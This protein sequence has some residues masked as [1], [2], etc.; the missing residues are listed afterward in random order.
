MSNKSRVH[1]IGVFVYLLLLTTT[2]A[3]MDES[4]EWTDSTGRFKVTAKLREVQDDSVFLITDD[5]RTLKIAIER[6]SS[7]DQEFL[8]SGANPFEDVGSLPKKQSSHAAW[9]KDKTVNWDAAKEVVFTGGVPWN[10]PIPNN[11]LKFEPSRAG[12]RKKAN[13][14]EGMHRLAINPGIRRAVAGFTVSFSVPRPLTRLSLIDVESGKAIHSEQVEANMKPL[15]LLNDGSTILM[16][17]A[18]KANGSFETPG[19]LQLWR[20]KGKKIVRTASWTP[21]PKA[22]RSFGRVVDGAIAEAYPIQGSLVLTLTNSASL[23]LWDIYKQ[24]PIWFSNLNKQNFGVSVS[25]DR[26][27]VAVFN[28]KTVAVAEV[29]TGKILGSI[30]IEARSVGWNRICWSPSGKRLL[31][32]SIGDLRVVNVESGEVE[33]D[34]HLSDAPVATGALAYPH[35]DF[36]LLD[37]KLLVH[38]PSRIRVCNYTGASSI[39]TVGSTSFIAVSGSSGGV[40]VPA[41]FPHKTAQEM[42]SKAQDDPTLFLIHPGVKVSVDVAGVPGRF[43][44]EVR[45]G[46][47]ESANKSG[48][49]LSP[50]APLKLVAQ[51][52]GPTTEAT[53]YIGHGS[54]V[55]N[56]YK[57]TIKILWQGKVLWHRS[58]TNIPHMLMTQGNETVEDALRRHGEKPNVSM[59]ANQRFPE[60]LQ[61]PG[62]S[63]KPGIQSNALMSSKFT[64]NGL[65]DTK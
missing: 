60:Y 34:F 19:Q 58:G 12:L 11:E 18:D 36:A 24:Q 47:E 51:I 38:L 54:H 63:S 62:Q 35:E 7:R 44:E 2:H 20:L 14:H 53:S 61:E 43:R 27:L 6:L 41:N 33:T 25:T 29:A 8:K 48:Y 3:Q 56:Q 42:L 31:L 50:Q 10:V 17:G 1:A 52:T 45:K 15:A 28:N 22:H 5:G 65:V 57:S 55:V 46:V 9:D 16:R 64:V 4:R 40:V 59:F 23:A 21:Y 32:S 37:N 49:E 26:K 39:E 30:G 13:F